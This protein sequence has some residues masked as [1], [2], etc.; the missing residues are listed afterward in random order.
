M[1]IAFV[2]LVP[3]IGAAVLTAEVTIRVPDADSTTMAVTY[4]VVAAAARSQIGIGESHKE[5]REYVFPTEG[6]EFASGPIIVSGVSESSSGKE[7]AW[8]V[9]PAPGNASSEA[10]KIFYPHPL[11][12]QGTKTTFTVEARSRNVSKE[13]DGRFVFKYET[14]HKTT[15]E[16]PEG[17]RLVYTNYPVTLYERD[18]LTYAEATG[19]ERKSLLFKTRTQ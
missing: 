15:F 2:C 14:S 19:T 6:F 18:G 4:T 12:L 11:T 5:T 17:H 7:L 16:V 8:E 13:D 9:V 1:R 3:L 10:I